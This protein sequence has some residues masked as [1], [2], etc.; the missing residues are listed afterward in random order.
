[1]SAEHE[2]WQYLPRRMSATDLA[3]YHRLLNQA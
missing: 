2:S 3:D 1:M